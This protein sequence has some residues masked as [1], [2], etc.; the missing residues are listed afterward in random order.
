MIKKF[1]IFILMALMLGS[2]S[3]QGKTSMI[4]TSFSYSDDLKQGDVFIWDVTTNFIEAEAF[5]E[6]GSIIKLEVLQDLAGKTFSGDLASNE[7]GDYFALQFGTSSFISDQDSIHTVV[8]PDEVTLDNGTILNP[9][10]GLWID[11]I[12][13]IFEFDEAD[14]RVIY[15]EDVAA[16][17][18]T[19]NAEVN[20]RESGFDA[21]AEVNSTINT[22]L[23][24]VKDLSLSVV[25]PALGAQS[26]E[27]VQRDISNVTSD[28]DTTDDDAV[29]INFLW[30]ALPIF[31]IPLI[32]KY[33]N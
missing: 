7:L 26:I 18:L 31:M 10:Q 23:G 20:F 2:I 24:V 25:V 17:M 33:R 29:P 4:V 9:L 11:I 32:K 14:V 27:F 8:F 21:Y 1:A 13:G 6:D 15:E 28:D 22:K 5:F 19:V 30:F 3:A 16:N 12:V